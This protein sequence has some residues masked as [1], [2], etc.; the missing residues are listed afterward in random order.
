MTHAAITAC[1]TKVE[2]LIDMYKKVPNYPLEMVEEYPLGRC[3]FGSFSH[4]A[5]GNDSLFSVYAGTV[6][7]VR[8]VSVAYNE[9][10]A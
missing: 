7:Q 4:P 5:P 6:Y 10:E 8:R 3:T 2:N 1:L 9:L